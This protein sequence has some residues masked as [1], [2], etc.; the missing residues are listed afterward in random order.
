M[1]IFKTGSADPDP[2]KI[3]PDPQHIK[4]GHIFSVNV[5]SLL[6][7]RNLDTH[8]FIMTILH[9]TGVPKT[10]DPHQNLETTTRM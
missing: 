6:S 1:R 8:N 3:G 9:F 10:S 2:I 5:H 7:K 4:H